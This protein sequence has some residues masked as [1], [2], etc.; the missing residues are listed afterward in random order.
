MGISNIWIIEHRLYV[1]N[2]YKIYTLKTV[3]DLE[4]N[5][6][7]INSIKVQKWKE[8]VLFF[9]FICRSMLYQ[10]WIYPKGFGIK[11]PSR[12][13]REKKQNK[14]FLSFFLEDQ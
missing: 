6:H 11:K 8:K 9:T 12:N 13:G 5:W 14:T 10:W 1:V 2:K 3:R 7:K 4:D